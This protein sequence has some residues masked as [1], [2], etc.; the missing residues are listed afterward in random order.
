MLLDRTMCH[1]F[2]P[3]SFEDPVTGKMIH[4]WLEPIA[5]LLEVSVS[6]YA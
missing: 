1:Q 4:F 5:K 3:G 2:A 6:T